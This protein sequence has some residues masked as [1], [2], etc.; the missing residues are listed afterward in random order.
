MK[1]EYHGTSY[2]KEFIQIGSE[3]LNKVKR[4]LRKPKKKH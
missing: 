4:N 1:E 3:L 2:K